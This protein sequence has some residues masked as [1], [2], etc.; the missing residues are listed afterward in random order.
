MLLVV[1]LGKVGGVLTAFNS[2]AE[3]II[4]SEEEMSSRARAPEIDDRKNNLCALG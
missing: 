1:D 4:C 3:T 2:G